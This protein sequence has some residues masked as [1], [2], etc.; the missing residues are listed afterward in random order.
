MSRYEE[1]NAA[2][3]ELEKKI[4]DNYFVSLQ[5]ATFAAHTTLL[6]QIALSLA[7]IADTLKERRANE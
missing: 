7:D 1:T 3:Q 6:E 2:I 5:G 4:R